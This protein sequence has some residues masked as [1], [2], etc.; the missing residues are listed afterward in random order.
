MQR[1]LYCVFVWF[2]QDEY[3]MTCEEDGE[4]DCQLVDGV[5]GNVLQHQ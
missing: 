1:Y 5:A 2:C 4:Y 3:I